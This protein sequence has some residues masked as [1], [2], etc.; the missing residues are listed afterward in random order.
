M[1]H[2]QLYGR[3]FEASSVRGVHSAV[4]RYEADARHRVQSYTVKDGPAPK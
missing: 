2:V 4:E 3:V 1:F